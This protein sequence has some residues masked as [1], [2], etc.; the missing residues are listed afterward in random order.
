MDRPDVRLARMEA[1]LQSQWF[2]PRDKMVDIYELRRL[3]Y[4]GIPEKPGLRPMCWK[5]LLQLLPLDKSQWESTLTEKRKKYLSF[6]RDFIIDVKIPEEG[7]LTQDVDSPLY[8]EAN[9]A[10]VTYHRDS[11]MLE[12]IKKDIKRTY[13]DFGFFQQLVEP[14]EHCVLTQPVTKDFHPII[15]PTNATRTYVPNDPIFPQLVNPTRRTVAG[16]RSS[17][18]QSSAEDLTLLNPHYQLSNNSAPLIK[19]IPRR[20]S[21][22]KANEIFAPD[23]SAAAVA[24]EESDS[25]AINTSRKAYFMISDE[26]SDADYNSKR[27]SAV[28]LHEALFKI[29]GESKTLS[30]TSSLERIVYPPARSSSCTQLR[31]REQAVPSDE[32]VE[33]VP[34]QDGKENEEREKDANSNTIFSDSEITNGLSTKYATTRNPSKSPNQ[35]TKAIHS[36]P[37]TKESSS[38]SAAAPRRISSLNLTFTLPSSSITIAN[39]RRMRRKLLE[40]VM[41][42][43]ENFNPES[44]KKNRLDYHS[45]VLE[46][47]LFIYSKLNPCVGYVQGMNEI[48]APLYWVFATDPDPVAKANA[49]SDT[50]FCFSI[51][52]VSARDHFIKSMDGEISGGIG[53]LLKR[54]ESLLHRRDYALWSNLENKGLRPPFYAF[55]WLTVLCC[56][57]W[58]LP[59]VIRLWDSMLSDPPFGI[60]GDIV[61]KNRNYEKFRFLLDF[62]CS[63]V[64]SIRDLIISEPFDE[65]LLLLQKYPIKNLESILLRTFEFRRRDEMTGFSN[66]TFYDDSDRLSIAS[67]GSGFSVFSALSAFSI[68]TNPTPRMTPHSPAN[69]LTVPVPP[70]RKASRMLSEDQ[71]SSRDST[72]N[73]S[74]STFVD[75]M[76]K[77]SLNGRPVSPVSV[78]SKRSA[79]S[80]Q[81]KP[82]NSSFS[83]FSFLQR[84][85]KS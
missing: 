31:T 28:G 18:L 72:I 77:D 56:Q 58:P 65:N 33:E 14:S 80:S 59:S 66:K 11:A 4:L 5:V 82:V 49:E 52:M 27:S 75:S 6:I 81:Q 54:F 8:A 71:S 32:E 62:C 42:F 50:Y 7:E 29:T 55:R 19:P 10:Y 36:R 2:N 73:G 38:G 41:R 15:P 63:M 13:A 57:D 16:T 47:I 25:G 60:A 9:T 67:Y 30:R 69:T 61:H 46:R 45:E 24:E 79:R 35:H 64:I 26:E 39:Q 76:K 40:R 51:L 53:A 78:S 70:P 48:L 34:R 84:L 21:L 17:S 83:R 44:V 20:S 43:H 12:Q 68:Q 3:C 74:S 23:G 22:I 85:I 37:R 1:I